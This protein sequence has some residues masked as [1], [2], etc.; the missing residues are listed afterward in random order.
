MESKPSTEVTAVVSIIQLI[1]IN[2]ADSI[3]DL[4]F[5]IQLKWSDNN[6]KYSFL[7]N[8]P[9]LNKIN[10]NLT[11]QIWRPNI[12]FY[13][14]SESKDADFE[15]NIFVWKQS[16][17]TLVYQDY[18]SEEKNVGLTTDEIYEGASN[19]LELKMERRKRF[20]CSFD[21]IRNYPFGEQI[22]QLTFFI[23][24]S[25]NQLTNLKAERLVENHSKSVGE[26]IVK[27]WKMSESNFSATGV[28]VI[29]VSMSLYRELQSVF[30]VTY[31]PTILMNI[32]NQATNY[33]SSQ[34]RVGFYNLLL[35]PYFHT[36]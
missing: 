19:Q 12:K 33:I 7:K 14:V 15:D 18:E 21:E 13:L 25:S 17:P 24:G 2:E 20:T 32:I 23:E 9:D 22:C 3:F 6:I 31:L 36:H 29:I 8:D 16:E 28:K 30:I 4:F 10:S 26:Y 5:K 34:N 27:E 35:F 11:K 1:E